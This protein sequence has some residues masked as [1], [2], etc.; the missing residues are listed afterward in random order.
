ME[1]LPRDLVIN[2]LAIAQVSGVESK[3]GLEGGAKPLGG[4]LPHG[5]VALKMNSV[6]HTSTFDM[7]FVFQRN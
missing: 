7:K 6:C 4:T 2:L 3:C 1:S 5:I